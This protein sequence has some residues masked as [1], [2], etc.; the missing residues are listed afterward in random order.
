MYIHTRI[1]TDRVTVRLLLT[2]KQTNGGRENTRRIRDVRLLLTAC[3]SQHGKEVERV[4][5]SEAGGWLVFSC[6]STRVMN[7]SSN[8]KCS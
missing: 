2:D 1:D 5:H 3:M 8:A 4:P 7:E 6:V